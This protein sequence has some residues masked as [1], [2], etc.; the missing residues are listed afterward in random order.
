MEKDLCNIS[1]EGNKIPDFVVAMANYPNIQI[2]DLA[3]SDEVWEDQEG[4]FYATFMGDRLSPNVSGTVE[5]KLF[6]GDQLKDFSIFVM[7]E[8]SDVH[9][10]LFYCNFINIGYEQSRGQKKITE[11]VNK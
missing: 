1:V 9:S 5:N 4:V 2:T 7:C 10:D 6:T 11:V 3:S 8:W